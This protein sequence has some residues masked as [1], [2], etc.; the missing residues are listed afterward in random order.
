MQFSH[1]FISHLTLRVI[2][3]QLVHILA[4]IEK[5][6]WFECRKVRD[7]NARSMSLRGEK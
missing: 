7:T 3:D 2:I 6:M 1:Q 5:K 4:W